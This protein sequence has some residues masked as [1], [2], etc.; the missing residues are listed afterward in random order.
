MLKH[1]II[2]A[3]ILIL[4]VFI[5]YAVYVSEPKITGDANLPLSGAFS[6]FPF[7]LGLDL[8]GGTRLVYKADISQV[9]SGEVSDSMDALRDV[10]ERRVNLFGVTEPIVQLEEGS[11]LGGASG[12][13]RLIVELPGVTDAVAAAKM[14][15]ETPVLEFK[16]ERPDSSRKRAIIAAREAFQKTGAQ[17]PLLS[18]DPYYVDTGLTGRFLKRAIVG[19]DQTTGEPRVSLEFNDEGTSLFGKITKENIN[20]TIAIYLDG[21]PISTPVVREEISNGRAEITGNFTP[22]EAKQL[23]GRLNSGALP[24]PIALLSTQV[25]GAPLGEKA[26]NDGVYAGLIGLISIAIFLIVWYRLPGLIAVLALSIY[27]ALMLMFF[28]LISV[29]LTAAAIAGFILSVG[30]AVDANI[31]IAERTKEELRR[32]KGIKDSIAEGF[33]RAW[34][35]IR[36]SNISSII[37]GVILFWFGTS[38][39]EGFALT[40]VLGVLVSMFSAITVTRT[41]L[42]ALGIS[43]RTGL[44]SFLFSSGWHRN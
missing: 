29:T 14:I 30:M 25:I 22:Q 27:V 42:Y 3:A 16:S 34:S 12:E 11:A 32:G 39:I 15:G 23:V 2:T 17:N 40:F 18:E 5:G 24:V 38:L 4:G 10:V 36:D 21:A 35:S 1:R 8:S 37:T 33:T 31:L 13:K 43:A 7:K 44:T 20:K 6:K 41:F 26:L 19:F 9:A 28:K